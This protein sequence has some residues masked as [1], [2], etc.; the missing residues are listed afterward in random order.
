MMQAVFGDARQ[1]GER[2]AHIVVVDDDVVD[3][4]L[5]NAEIAGRYGGAYGVVSESSAGKT[6]TALE[7]MQRN[8]K[9][10]AVVLARQWMGEM[11]GSDLL[12]S[13]RSLH[14]RA[15]RVLLISPGDWG[16]ERTADAIRGAIASGCVDH[17]LSKPSTAA[18]ESFHR[19]ISGFLYEWTSSEEGSAYEVTARDE[20]HFGRAALRGG[21]DRFDVAVVGAGP[22]GLAA[23]VYGS[24]EGLTTVVVER[25][26]IG[27]QAGSSSMIRNY[28]GFAR[29]IGGAEL[30]RQ[31]YEQA[32]VFGTRFLTG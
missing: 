27:G 8:G 19:A 21:S 3:L 20:H 11:N 18:D 23:A 7:A 5:L 30:A 31:A 24:S 12:S 9:R 16:H 13:L 4:E 26:T 15:K 1:S 17:Y 2:R 28:L 10:V 29:G 32:W 14:P 25:G 22:A 6:L